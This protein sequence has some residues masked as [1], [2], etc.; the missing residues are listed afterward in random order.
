MPRE[1]EETD[2]FSLP[3]ASTATKFT[4]GGLVTYTI[5]EQ[6]KHQ[7]NPDVVFAHLLNEQFYL[8]SIPSNRLKCSR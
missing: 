5:V 6:I 4:S 2:P 7:A 1:E 8:V 3:T